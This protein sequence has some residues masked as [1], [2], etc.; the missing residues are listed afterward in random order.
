MN[1]SRGTAA[2]PAHPLNTEAVI[3]ITQR[4]ELLEALCS[5]VSADAL[6]GA[7]GLGDIGQHFPDTDARWK[8]A[9]SRVFVRRCLGT[10]PGP[11]HDRQ[12][13]VRTAG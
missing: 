6:L 8:G 4:T 1:P 11:R 13:G 3:Y 7:A 9:D 10:R 2:T 5:A 12:P